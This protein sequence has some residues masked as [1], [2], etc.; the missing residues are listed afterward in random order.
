MTS[1]TEQQIITIHILHNILRKSNLVMKFGPLIK[2]IVRNIF[3][4]KLC[5]QWGREPSYRPFSVFKKAISK[6]KASDQYPSL[7]IL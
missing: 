2:Y 7:N 4:Q 6:V 3:L 5:G 1:Q